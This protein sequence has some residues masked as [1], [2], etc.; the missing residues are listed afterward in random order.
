MTSKG[1]LINQLHVEHL[2]SSSQKGSF[3]GAQV[4]PVIIFSAIIVSAIII[5]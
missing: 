3:S 4:C 1:T 2:N 5:L